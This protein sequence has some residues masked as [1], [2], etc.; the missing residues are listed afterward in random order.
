MDSLQL[1]LPEPSSLENTLI[2][3]RAGSDDSHQTDA[4]KL[5]GNHH[6]RWGSSHKGAQEL[7]QLYSRGTI[8]TL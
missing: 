1:R 8:L 7:A 2:D 5:E 4:Y 3:D 6:P